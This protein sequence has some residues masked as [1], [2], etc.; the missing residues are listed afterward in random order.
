MD[1]LAF[2]P[3]CT[4]EETI[5]KPGGAEDSRVLEPCVLTSRG[6]EY[7]E[8]KD[9]CYRALIDSL[10]E[11]EQTGDDMSDEC[12]DAGWNMEIKIE[13]RN[14]QPDGSRVDASCSASTNRA[15]DCPNLP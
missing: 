10:C 9:V 6:F 13:W 3:R 14:R 1:T 8:G 2:E 12:I 7:T 4:I 15:V 11:D 5:V